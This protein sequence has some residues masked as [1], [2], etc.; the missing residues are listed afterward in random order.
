MEIQLKGTP[1]SLDISSDLYTVFLR[2]K[3]T[4]ELVA[5]C[6]GDELIEFMLRRMQ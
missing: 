4:D 3:E 5:N 2:N 6:L 1:Y